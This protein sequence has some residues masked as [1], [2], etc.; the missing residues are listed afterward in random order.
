[1]LVDLGKSQPIIFAI[2]LLLH[3]RFNS[4]A[5]SK[6]WLE[7]AD[8]IIITSWQTWFHSFLK[9]NFK[10]GINTPV[11]KCYYLKNQI[12]LGNLNL[13]FM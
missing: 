5:Q 1:V 4:T 12:L 7:L 6:E 2:T 10:I 11:N 13:N 8:Q 9:N 3:K